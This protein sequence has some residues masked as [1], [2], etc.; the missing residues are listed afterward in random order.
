MSLFYLLSGSGNS[1]FQSNLPGLNRAGSMVSSL[2]VAII[3]LTLVFLSNP[4]I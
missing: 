3:T 4:S 2:L 1:I